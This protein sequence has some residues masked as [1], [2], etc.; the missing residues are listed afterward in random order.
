[1]SVI[2][3]SL[4]AAAGN[5]AGSLSYWV[6]R[7]QTSI[8][9]EP[10][11][12]ATV[13]TSN[14][15][16]IVSTASN[17]AHRFYIKLDYDGG[18]L[19][20]SDFQTSGQRDVHAS[21]AI[22]SNN[23]HFMETNASEYGYAKLGSVSDSTVD[24]V[25]WNTNTELGSS[26]YDPYSMFV[27][28]DQGTGTD[29]LVHARGGN[30]EEYF[31]GYGTFYQ[32]RVGV[33]THNL[34]T[35]STFNGKIW[36]GPYE[37]SG[38]GAR[39]T[40]IASGSGQKYAVIWSDPAENK[41]KFA[42]YSSDN[43]ISNC[44]YNFVQYV[45]SSNMEPA[46][47]FVDPDD[48]MTA[49]TAVTT[50]QTWVWRAS[51]AGT[52]EPT[53]RYAFAH[54]T[55]LGQC[56]SSAMDSDGNVY[57][58][59]NNGYLVKFSSSNTIEWCLKIDNT[60]AGNP[61]NAAYN[62]VKVESIDDTEFLLISINFGLEGSSNFPVYVIKAPLDLNNY[63][64]T[65]GNIQVSTHSFSPTVTFNNHIRDGGGSNVNTTYPSPQGG[66]YPNAAETVTVTTSDI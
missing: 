51:V 19:G 56:S 64:G 65:Y 14:Q 10:S 21:L 60:Q 30:K 57:I 13:N 62:E 5:A 38:F 12:R 25:R 42:T 23:Y 2:S 44:F 61:M 16:V 33:A 8:V 27:D 40:M 37:F 46:G 20:A 11:V 39:G 1:M 53:A 9:Y 34:G 26:F 50:S 7:I 49:V 41:T 31:T 43:T 22:G 54:G 52:Y 3:R 35:N 6:D 15:E 63:T 32:P 28:F 66:T 48:L 47:L 18:L 36:A 17:N 55:T 58:F 24:R 59:Y 45:Y 4:I 29:F